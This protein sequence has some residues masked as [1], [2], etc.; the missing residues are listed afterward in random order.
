MSASTFP[1][2]IFHCS[3]YLPTLLLANLINSP[4]LAADIQSAN[5]PQNLQLGIHQVGS[6][7]ATNDSELIIE[8]HQKNQYLATLKPPC[9]GLDQAK[10]IAFTSHGS[11]TLNQSSSVVLPNGKRCRFSSFGQQSTGEK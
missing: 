9:I 3:Y 5:S 10:S 6:W 4:V 8:D 1:F 7:R 11:S 2:R